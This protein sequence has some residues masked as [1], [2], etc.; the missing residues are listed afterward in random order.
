MRLALEQAQT[1][2]E[3]GEV[4][5]GAVIVHEGKVIGNGRNFRE[6]HQDPLAHAEIFAIAEAAKALGSWRLIGATCYVTLEPC[7]M[8]AGALV[9][10]R[11]ARVVYG[12]DDPKAGAVKSLYEIGNDPR[13]NHRFELTPGV[14]AQECGQ[15]LSAFFAEVRAKRKT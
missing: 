8:C 14:L 6:E 12:A 9:L 15:V 2:R 5:V 11:V 4:P 7:P 10:A 1:A 3:H 13:L